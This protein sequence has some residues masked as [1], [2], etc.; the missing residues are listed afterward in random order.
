MKDFY[1]AQ[2]KLIQRFLSKF[3][4]HACLCVPRFNS[5]LNLSASQQQPTLMYHYFQNQ[6]D[7]INNVTNHV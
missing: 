3:I 7:F 2:E 5:T 1:V 4:Y 6:D